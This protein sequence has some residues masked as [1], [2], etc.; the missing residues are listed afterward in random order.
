[1][2]DAS[3]Y[4]SA[5]G[6]RELKD[7]Y[8][9]AGLHPRVDGRAHDPAR[10][11]VPDRTQVEL[12]LAWAFLPR[13]VHLPKVL[14]LRLSRQIR[15]AVRSAIASAA[16]RASSARKLWPNSGLSRCT[17]NRVLDRR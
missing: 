1:M 15:Q 6:D 11:H 8:R 2:H 16:A 17:L 9:E 7:H 13:P 10:E 12:P 5:A 3:G 4:R 14:H